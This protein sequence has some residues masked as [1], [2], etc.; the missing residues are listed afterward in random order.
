VTTND[1][2]SINDHSIITDKPL[3]RTALTFVFAGED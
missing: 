1:V 3:H 2:D